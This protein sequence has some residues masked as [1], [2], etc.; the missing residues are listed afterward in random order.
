MDS[1]SQVSCIS[2]S[3]CQRLKLKPQRVSLWLKGTGDSIV[4]NVKKSAEVT[5]RPHFDSAFAC[6]VKVLVLSE[7]SSYVP[8]LI[9][10]SFELPDFRG[11]T[12]ANPR[13]MDRAHTDVL[14]GADIYAKIMKASIRRGRPNEPVAM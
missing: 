12:L 14:L 9:P 2:E 11:L 4:A 10:T 3:L 8:L 6:S 13:Y 5:I 1:C 7:V